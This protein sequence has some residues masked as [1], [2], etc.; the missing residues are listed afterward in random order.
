MKNG[1][2][3]MEVTREEEEKTDRNTHTRRRLTGRLF[4]VEIMSLVFWMNRSDVTG[5]R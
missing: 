3:V 1:G 2:R 5:R 4:E